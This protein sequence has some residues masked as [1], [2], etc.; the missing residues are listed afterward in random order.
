MTSISHLH[1]S[2]TTFENSSESRLVTD[3]QGVIR[4]ANSAL[5]ELLGTR[6]NFLVG[7]PLPFF[8]AR[9]QRYDFYT[10]L[11]HLK[12]V[13]VRDWETCLQ[14]LHGDP[15]PVA[16]SVRAHRAE[17]GTLERLLW[18]VRE[19]HRQMD[20]PSETPNTLGLVMAILTHESRGILQRCQANLER[21]RWRLEGQPEALALLE[22]AYRAQADLN[23]LHQQVHDGTNWLN[24]KTSPCDLGSIWRDAWEDACA[25]HPE[26]ML[27]LQEE[28]NDVNLR[29]TVDPMF[30]RQVFR[31]IFDNSIAANADKVEIHCEIV[32]Q[33]DHALRITIADNGPGLSDEQRRRLF[34]PFYTTKLKG[35]GLGMSIVR[36]IVMAHGGHIQIGTGRGSGTVLVI[37]VPQA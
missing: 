22:G 24:L 37:T 19:I 3:S 11:L 28:T 36:H 32:G 18:F 2:A 23:R 20:A 29:V 35:T 8:I 15:I 31:N 10:E 17:D 12:R 25:A 27:T 33:D 9:R 13:S 30:F 5:A 26:G 7:H 4:Q 16:L 34:E 1:W 14:P 21:L 6:Q